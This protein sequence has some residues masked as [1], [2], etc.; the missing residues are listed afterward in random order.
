MNNFPGS[1]SWSSSPTPHRCPADLHPH[2]QD[3][4]AEVT[5]AEAP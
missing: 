5:L 3:I 2:R 4:G 1:K